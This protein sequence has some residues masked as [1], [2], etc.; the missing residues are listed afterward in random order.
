MMSLRHAALVVRKTRP[1]DICPYGL[2]GLRLARVAHGNTRKILRSI[3]YIHDY[4]PFDR[5]R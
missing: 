3:V 2:R 1:G 4:L 5:I